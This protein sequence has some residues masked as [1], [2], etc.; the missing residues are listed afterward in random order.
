VT[1]PTTNQVAA[2]GTIHELGTITW[3]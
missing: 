3:V 1:V 2:A